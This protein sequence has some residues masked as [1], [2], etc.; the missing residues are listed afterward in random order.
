M[1]MYFSDRD[2]DWTDLRSVL[3]AFRT[4]DQLQ[5]RIMG[6]P[7]LSACPAWKKNPINLYRLMNLYRLFNLRAWQL[8]VSR[9]RNYGG[10]FE[11]P[12]V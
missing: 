5:G 10:N 2:A 8:T 7:L 4:C 11:I 9:G 3:T 12:T 1:E 6:S